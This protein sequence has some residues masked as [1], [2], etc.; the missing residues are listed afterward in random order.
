MTDR[1]SQIPVLPHRAPF[2]LVDRLE[3]ATPE[4]GVGVKLVA[5]NDPCVTA[6]GVLPA[7]FVLEALAQTGGA[8]LNALGGDG[9]HAGLLAQIEAFLV[10][11]AVRAGDELR[12]EVRVLR[13]LGTATVLEG[14]ATVEGALCAEGRFVL[15]AGG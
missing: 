10:H 12:I 7:A 8:Y 14:R 4:R 6:G 13:R 2:R 9:T 3:E 1:R 11:A 5:A 15:V